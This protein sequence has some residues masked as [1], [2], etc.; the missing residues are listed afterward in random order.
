MYLAIHTHMYIAVHNAH[1]HLTQD[2]SKRESEK[3]SE[4]KKK[5]KKRIQKIPSQILFFF[6]AL[7]YYN[8]TISSI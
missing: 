4:K 5:K 3:E 2:Q 7:K 1:T 8:N 6:F